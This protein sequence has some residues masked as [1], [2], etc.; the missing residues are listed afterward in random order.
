MPL[1]QSCCALLQE[2][3]LAELISGLFSFPLAIQHSAQAATHAPAAIQAATRLGPSLCAASP[4]HLADEAAQGVLD[5]IVQSGMRSR[6]PDLPA[7]K[8]KAVGELAGYNTRISACRVALHVCAY[9]L[10]LQGSS[11]LQDT[12]ALGRIFDCFVAA[13]QQ[14][15]DFEE[16][17][18]REEEQVFKTK[19]QTSKVMTDEVRLETF[20]CRSQESV[21]TWLALLM[22]RVSVNQLFVPLFYFCFLDLQRDY[23]GLLHGEPGKHVAGQAPGHTHI[24]SNLLFSNIAGAGRSLLPPEVPGPL[25]GLLRYLGPG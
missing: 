5:T 19:T 16:A 20:G 4:S 7:D 1:T 25:R 11:G 6:Q 9:E 17:R 24:A 22:S 10:A 21:S 3:L 18:A 12:S 2:T 8:M 15:K 13:W 23:A 14:L